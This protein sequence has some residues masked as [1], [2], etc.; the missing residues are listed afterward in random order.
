MVERLIHLAILDD[1]L[2]GKW[3]K[4]ERKWCKNGFC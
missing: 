4:M 1:V 2:A 3:T